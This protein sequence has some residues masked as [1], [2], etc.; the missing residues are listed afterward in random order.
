MD[1]A[2]RVDVGN[3]NTLWQDAVLDSIKGNVDDCIGYQ[4]ITGH[5]IFDIKPSEGFHRKARYVAGGHQTDSPASITYSSVVTRDSVRIIPKIVALNGLDMSCCDIKNTYLAADCH[6]KILIKAG[7]D[8]GPEH[9]RTW[10][11]V[12]K[13]LCGLKSSGAAFRSFLAKHI[14][15][16]R[17]KPPRADPDCWMHPATKPNGFMYYEYNM[18]VYVD[19]ILVASHDPKPIMEGIKL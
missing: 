17:F 7:S 10:L 1:D 19:D 9:Q 13:A 11:L 14:Y 4:R 3:D 18:L 5:L 2:K 6:E 15:N 8:F 16:L 12:R